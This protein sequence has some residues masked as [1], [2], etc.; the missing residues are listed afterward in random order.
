MLKE[1][2]HKEQ[3]IMNSRTS[4]LQSVIDDVAFYEMC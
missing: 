2:I 1:E 3:L 4:R